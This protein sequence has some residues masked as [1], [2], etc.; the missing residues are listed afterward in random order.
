MK[1]LLIWVF[2][3]NILFLFEE[4]E[5]LAE[6][7]LSEPFTGTGFTA[8]GA[9]YS[10]HISNDVMNQMKDKAIPEYFVQFENPLSLKDGAFLIEMRG[11]KN[12]KVI[13]R[14][15]EAEKKIYTF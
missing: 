9:G 5:E 11:N 13:A 4:D 15:S 12:M 3:K 8:A 1:S 7:Y 2:A 10:E 6:K 14:Y